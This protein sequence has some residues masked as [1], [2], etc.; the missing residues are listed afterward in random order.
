MSWYCNSTSSVT[1][2]LVVNCCVIWWT[3]VILKDVDIGLYQ[4]YRHF[5]RNN[6]RWSRVPRTTFLPVD[7]ILSMCRSIY[8]VLSNTPPTRL[9]T[10]PIQSRTLKSP[11]RTNN[12][13][14]H[15]MLTI[16]RIP[17][18]Y[19]GSLNGLMG[20]FQPRGWKSLYTMLGP[21]LVFF[22]L[23]RVHRAFPVILQKWERNKLVCKKRIHIMRILAVLYDHRILF[24]QGCESNFFLLLRLF[25]SLSWFLSIDLWL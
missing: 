12:G 3:R 8:D 21:E 13:T 10:I 17:V 6:R 14:I 11:M 2:I 15:W 9:T 22:G 24:M 25:P 18:C 23:A 16:S 1:Q 4:I 19:G 7:N 20:S 5:R